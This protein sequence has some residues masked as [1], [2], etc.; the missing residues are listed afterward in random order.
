MHGGRTVQRAVAAPGDVNTTQYTRPHETRDDPRLDRTQAREARRVSVFDRGIVS[1]LSLG[2]PCANAAPPGWHA[3]T[4]TSAYKQMLLKDP[5][6]KASADVGV[7]PV[8]QLSWIGRRKRRASCAVP[9]GE[10][11]GLQALHKGIPDRV[12]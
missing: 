1:E 8:L 12:P 7:P 9:M 4:K 10:T 11:L 2:A 6:M 3:Q 5:S